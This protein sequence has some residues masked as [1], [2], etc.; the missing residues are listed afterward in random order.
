M[1]YYIV[2]TKSL[3]QDP[4]HTGLKFPLYPT[5]HKTPGKHVINKNLIHCGS[6]SIFFFGQTVNIIRKYLGIT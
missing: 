5:R 3:L 4:F 6:N 2:T 1:E